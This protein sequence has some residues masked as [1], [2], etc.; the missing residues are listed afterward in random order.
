MFIRLGSLCW[1]RACALL[2]TLCL[3]DADVASAQS[4]SVSQ[5][6]ACATT[7]Q[8]ALYCWGTLNWDGERTRIG[9]HPDSAALGKLTLGRGVRLDQ[10]EIGWLHYC[11]VT[12]D[13]VVRCDGVDYGGRLGFRRA[14]GSSRTVPTA[15]RFISVVAGESHTCGLTALGKAYCWG[16]NGA[17]Q[18]GIGSRVDSVAAPTAVVGGHRFRMI[19]AGS[20]HTC[21]ITVQGS[22]LCWGANTH[23]ALGRHHDRINC[24]LSQACM[25]V[26]GAL[27]VPQD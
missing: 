8:G 13:G 1:L 6:S 10:V 11:G 23:S 14:Y 24:A 26:P 5:N 3:V 22:T 12:D 18:T 19:T 4:V 15:L 25:A 20:R 7:R 21:G 2:L 27:D 16:D 17:G 9:V